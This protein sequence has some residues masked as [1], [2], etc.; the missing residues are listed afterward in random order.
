MLLFCGR[1]RIIAVQVHQVAP[2]THKYSH[3]NAGGL[4]DRVTELRYVDVLGNIAIA[5]QRRSILAAH[6]QPAPAAASSGVD[7]DVKVVIFDIDDCLY[8]VTNGPEPHILG[9]CCTRECAA[10]RPAAVNSP[11]RLS[12]DCFISVLGFTTAHC[13]P[14]FHQASQWHRGAQV[15]GR[16]AGLRFA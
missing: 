3:M 5:M 11:C 7:R 4:N 16:K 12:F 2:L 8:P 15:Y 6:L 10:P 14:R 9:T 1:V 13:C